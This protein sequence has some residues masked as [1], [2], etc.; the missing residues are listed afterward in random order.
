MSGCH[1]KI[2]LHL[3]G[4]Q[5]VMFSI[6]T[7]IYLENWLSLLI[8]FYISCRLRITLCDPYRR[9]GRDSSV[10]IT[11]RYELDGPGIESRWGRDSSRPALGPARTPV[12]WVPGLTPGG[13]KRPGRSVDWPPPSSAEVKERVELYL[14]ARSG[15]SWPVVGWTLHYR[16][17]LRAANRGFMWATAEAA[18]GYAKRKPTAKDQRNGSDKIR[19][20][21]TYLNVKDALSGICIQYCA[22]ARAYVNNVTIANIGQWLY[23]ITHHKLY[24]VAC[25]S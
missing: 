7:Q 24:I 14:Y 20:Y 25:Y 3:D 18:A 2:A 12:Q 5:L 15:R 8:M 9:V 11:T 21:A 6:E 23:K 19:T 10:V 17:S 13:V 1:A 4:R 16:R 22:R